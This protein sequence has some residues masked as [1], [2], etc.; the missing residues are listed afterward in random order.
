MKSMADYDRRVRSRTVLLAVVAA[1]MV[2]VVACG[3]GGG[4]RPAPD[5]AP[6]AAA[7]PPALTGELTVFAAAS[8]TEAFTR[9]GK[10]FEAEHPGVKVTCNFGS[11]SSLVTQ[12]LQGAPADVFASADEANLRR[13]AEGGAAAGQPVVFARNELAVIVGRGN[14]KKIASVRDL[15]RPDLVVV[16]AAPQVP[17][18]AYAAEVFR[19][20]AVTV[21]PRSLETD[22]KAVVAKVTSGEADAGVVYATDV[23]AAGDRAEGIAI[24][25][26]LGVVATYPIVV[27]RE[28][29]NAAAADAFVSFVAGSRGQN[30]LSS[31]GF[32]AP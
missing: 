11:S 22:V 15:A 28:A 12:I 2:L 7:V 9:L 14:P 29:T 31:F 20:A 19:K 26:E 3:S 27:T 21:T 5:V 25:A 30:V 23:R 4:G 16:V 6:S 10:E 1:A 18:G 13:L 24:P 32:A 8:L 17:A